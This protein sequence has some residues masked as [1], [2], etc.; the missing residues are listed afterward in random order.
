MRVGM[1]CRS[2]RWDGEVGTEHPAL[3]RN[4]S[5]TG[6]GHEWIT[7]LG[8]RVVHRGS[9]RPMIGRPR[10]TIGWEGRRMPAH[11]RQGAVLREVTLA[12]PPRCRIPF[13]RLRGEAGEIGGRHAQEE[14]H[15]RSGIEAVRGHRQLL[16]VDEIRCGLDANGRALISGIQNRSDD[17]GGAPIDVAQA[18]GDDCEQDH[19]D[20]A[21]RDD[22]SNGPPTPPGTHVH[23]AAN[24][25]DERVGFDRR[26]LATQCGDRAADG[27]GA[28]RVA[29]VAGAGAVGGSVALVPHGASLLVEVPSRSDSAARAWWSVALTVPGAMP[30]RSAMASI[31]RSAP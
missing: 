27:I 13:R 18:D 20:A 1:L 6:D 2:T 7:G 31:D 23:V 4:R 10:R 9:G 21:G 25:V 8:N 30:S 29:A 22:E 11:L 5:V 17:M 3:D 28:A 12:D 14:V 26:H 16:A 15:G 24:R 19:D